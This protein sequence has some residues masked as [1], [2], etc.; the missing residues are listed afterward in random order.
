MGKTPIRSA[1]RLI[2]PHQ[3]PHYLKRNRKI[4]VEDYP[5]GDQHSSSSAQV[6][7]QL[8]NIGDGL[9]HMSEGNTMD[10]VK[11]FLRSELSFER[12]WE[13]WKRFPV[14]LYL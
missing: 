14:G 12:F 13:K 2:L 8:L 4:R 6:S 9:G 3:P 1:R 11:G 10:Q 7:V 5:T